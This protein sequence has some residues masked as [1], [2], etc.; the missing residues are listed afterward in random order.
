MS[1]EQFLR[2]DEILAYGE[3]TEASARGVPP[4]SD[5]PGSGVRCGHPLFYEVSPADLPPRLRRRAG[6]AGLRYVGALFAFDLDRPPAGRHYTGARFKVTLAGTGRRAVHLPEDAD[7][8]GLV[9][10]GDAIE[11][12][13]PVAARTVA[14]ARGRA[15]WLRRLFGRPGAPRAWTTGLQTPVFSWAYEE[16]RARTYAVHAVL[17]I[18]SAATEVT[19]TLSAQVETAGPGGRRSA[20]L[21]EAIPFAESLTPAEATAGAAVRLCVAADVVSYS[22]RSNLETEILQRDLVEVLGRARR[23]AGIAD[24]AVRP[25]PQ[26]DGQFTVLPVGIDESKVIPGLLHELGARLVERDTGM[27]ADERMRLRVALHRGLVK[28]GDNGWV[29]TS[30]IA[31]HRILDSAPLRAAVKENPAACYVLGLPDV[32]YRDVIE[33][34]VEPP[35][36]GDFHEMVVDLPEKQFVERGWFY[37]GPGAR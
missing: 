6:S 34:A 20:V 13:S 3:L 7:A 33:H 21:S 22:R 23:A 10:V 12:S 28:E 30:A 18:P 37:V 36:A 1:D 4:L 27:P 2:D 15:G 32:L 29:G 19:G 35:R 26:G 9:D 31:V 24:R 11:P 25:Q 5:E 14:A 16:P 17:E 8:L